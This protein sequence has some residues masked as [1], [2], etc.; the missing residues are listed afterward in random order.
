MNKLM[1]SI[2]GMCLAA[3]AYVAIVPF[4]NPLSVFNQ[5]EGEGDLSTTG[6]GGDQRDAAKNPPG[7]PTFRDTRWDE[8]GPKNWDQFKL[9]DDMRKDMRSMSDS[10]PRA[11]AMLK[12][13][14]EVW[15][16]APTN[17]VLDGKAVRIPGYI[18]PL[19]QNSEGLKELLLVPYFGACIHSPPPPSNQIIHVTLPQR[20]QGMRSMDTVWVRGTLRVSRSD[21]SMAPSSY[22]MTATSVEPYVAVK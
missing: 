10:D 3:A 4:P 20:A 12:K 16:D 9:V 8:L 11:V 13:M 17:P 5:S 15:D 14:K 21:S 18:V 19:D 7:R 6:T 22:L 1:I 2:V